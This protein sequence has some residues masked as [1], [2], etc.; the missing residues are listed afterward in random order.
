MI[1]HPYMK[2]AVALLMEKYNLAS[3]SDIKIEHIVDELIACQNRFCLKYNG[4]VKDGYV[5][6]HETSEEPNCFK[7][8]L[9]SPSDIILSPYVVSTDPKKLYKDLPKIISNLKEKSNNTESLTKTIFPIGGEY[10]RFSDT[11]SVGKANAKITNQEIGLISITTLTHQKP[12]SSRW[13]NK[14]LVNSCIIPDISIDATR[15]FITI[16]NR[17]KKQKGGTNW[18][19]GK[20]D[21]KGKKNQISR[22]RVF[23]GNFP[24]ASKS[25]YC[26][27]LSVLGYIG[28]LLKEKEFST[29]AKRVIDELEKNPIY[30]VNPIDSATCVHFSH[31]IIEIAKTGALN[32]IIDSLY[33]A[34]Y[35]KFK[36]LRRNDS[37]D[38]YKKNNIEIGK[39]GNWL[40]LEYDKFDYYTS[41]FL[42]LFNHYTFRE[43][44][45]CRME[46][47]SEIRIL[48]II[49]FQ[50]MEQ[51]SKEIIESAESLGAW[52]NR[53][54]FNAALMEVSP[55]ESCDE[56]K[57]DDSKKR[58]IEE[59]KYKTL[60]SLESSI[61]SATDNTAMIAN[62]IA[63]VGRLS[64]S[65]APKEAVP[66]IKAVMEPQITLPSAKNLLIAFSRVYSKSVNT[67][68]NSTQEE[69]KIDSTNY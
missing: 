46:Y 64:N 29:K 13:V 4:K 55:M 20:A 56:A 5:T 49:Y 41:K 6:F 39:D 43:F 15:D 59:L 69:T 16:F 37:L 9:E 2:Y 45:S 8:K 22:P 53:S 30:I 40:Y 18:F 32:K 67:K 57:K 65:D 47:P 61:F 68:T 19:K 38:L 14:I 36:G 54:A 58:K 42:T 26:K 11:G 62:I 52:I 50:N 17:L 44:L 51:I 33:D 27:S 35:Y 10:L 48:L 60:T 25:Y 21:K 31:F 28:E 1:E 7:N 3:E 34:K 12:C 23:S 66:F 24:N 63:Q